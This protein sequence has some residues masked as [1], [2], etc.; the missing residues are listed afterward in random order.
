MRKLNVME[1]DNLNHFK[2]V[3][4]HQFYIAPA[5]DNYLLARWMFINRFIPECFWQASQALEKYL[6]AI[7]LLNDMDT[8]RFKHDLSALY[9]AH[10]S[11]C[12][13]VAVASFIKPVA[14]DSSL[15]RDEKVSE[16]I[17]WISIKGDPQS[18]YGLVSWWRNSDDIVKVDQL[19]G[20][21]RR[22]TIG[23]GWQ[24]GQDFPTRPEDLSFIGQ[25]YQVALE[26]DKSFYPR[27]K[28]SNL[29][30]RL[31]PV[32]NSR[33]DLLHSWNFEF[34]RND[35]DLERP[36]PRSVAPIIGPAENSY[37]NLFRENLTR[38]SM[39][40]GNEALEPI[41]RVL[42]EGMQWLLDRITLSRGDRKTFDDLL[43][44]R[45]IYDPV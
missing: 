12:G 37:L 25:S 19:A 30:L 33:S 20:Q 23:M 32:G 21:L 26:R 39:V 45:A 5:D 24:V 1:F 36:A 10:L 13:S 15:W 28:M 35:V 42:A 40:N 9:H 34:P 17:K 43:K 11:I 6:K 14:L 31:I 16:F 3:A 4:T 41:S 8:K 2:S 38:K 29:D 44:G 7:I 22:L 18:R 27:G